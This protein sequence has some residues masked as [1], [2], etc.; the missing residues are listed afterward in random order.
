M[1]VRALSRMNSRLGKPATQPQM[2]YKP[3][4][5]DLALVEPPRDECVER[6]VCTLLSTDTCPAF[7]VENALFPSLFGLL[8][9][10]AIFAP[11]P[12]AFFHPFQSG[13]ADLYAPD[14]RRR[15]KA[16]LAV[17]M[18]HLES[19]EYKEVIRRN[20]RE[21]LGTSSA[22]V[23]WGRLSPQVLS[24]ALACIPAAHLKL[25]FERLQEDLRNNCNGLPDLVHFKP[26]EARYQ[27]IEIK[28]P[29]DKLQDNQRRWMQFFRTHD[30]P[31]VVGRIS[32]R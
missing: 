5:L 11:I 29:G 22:F 6:R 2:R 9:W 16:L 20:Y 3:E 26:D 15:R 1:I 19:G 7:Y 25:I 30:I 14:F 31:A 17:Q 18:A 24:L 10:D 23:R 12:G 28:A 13:P 32:W 27:L 21:K 4:V 8:C